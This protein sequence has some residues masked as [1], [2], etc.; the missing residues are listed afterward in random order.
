MAPV[1]TPVLLTVASN[2]LLLLQMPPVVRSVK[3][4][5]EPTQTLVMPVIVAG[6]KLTVIKWVAETVPQAFAWV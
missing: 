4:V 1:T 6:D 5:E 2:V 3:L